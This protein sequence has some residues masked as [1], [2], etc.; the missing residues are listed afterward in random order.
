MHFSLLHPSR[1]RKVWSF[2]TL[3]ASWRSSNMTQSWKR[4]LLINIIQ[5]IVFKRGL[6]YSASSNE[7]EKCFTF[8]IFEHW[9]M[10]KFITLKQQSPIFIYNAELTKKDAKTRTIHLEVS[11]ERLLLK[12]APSIHT[13]GSQENLPFHLHICN[14]HEIYDI[15]CEKVCIARKSSCHMH[16]QIYVLVPLMQSSI[17]S[18]IFSLKYRNGFIRVKLHLHCWGLVPSQNRE[19]DFNGLKIYW[20]SQRRI[21]KSE[22]FW[23]LSLPTQHF[24]LSRT[25]KTMATCW[26]P[27]SVQP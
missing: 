2:R 24:S 9:E 23:A 16:F 26:G 14:R 12:L 21:E 1:N 4:Q 25:D 17:V 8:A 7:D 6:F 18:S 19:R 13:L 27:I 5:T 3:I 15:S 22:L 10:I 20:I 11:N